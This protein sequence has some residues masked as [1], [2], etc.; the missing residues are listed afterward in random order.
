MIATR[1]CLV[2]AEESLGLGPRYPRVN[3]HIG[4]GASGVSLVAKA[5]RW[6]LRL[7]SGPLKLDLPPLS[8]SFN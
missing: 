5:P 7:A 4:H 6:M 3:L 1:A 8:V 2:L